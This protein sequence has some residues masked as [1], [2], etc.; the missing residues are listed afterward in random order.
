MN[1]IGLYWQLEHA[2]MKL[3]PLDLLL[4]VKNLIRQANIFWIKFSN[5]IYMHLKWK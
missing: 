4:D 3:Y 5:H 1:E 2:Y